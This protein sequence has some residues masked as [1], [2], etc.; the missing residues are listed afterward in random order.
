MGSQGKFGSCLTAQQQ[1]I[2]TTTFC[3]SGPQPLLTNHT[4][5]RHAASLVEKEHTS[6]DITS[7][8]TIEGAAAVAV[9]VSSHT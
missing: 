3:S 7:H 2:R 4:S 5:P 6:G 9:F 1:N 8:G